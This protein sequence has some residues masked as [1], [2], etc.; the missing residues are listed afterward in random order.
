MLISLIGLLGVANVLQ[1]GQQPPL[2]MVLWD[3]P[4]G[5]RWFMVRSAPFR[6]KHALSHGQTSVGFFVPYTWV[7]VKIKPPGDRRF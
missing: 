4:M 3:E 2:R 6:S 1:R 5:Q 7:W